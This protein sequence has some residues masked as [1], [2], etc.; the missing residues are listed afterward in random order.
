[1]KNPQEIAKTIKE[2]AKDKKITVG[3]ML[4]DCELG[5]NTL[6]SMQ[7]GGFFP[8]LEAINKIADYLG[9]SVDYLL[10]R[11]ENPNISV[12]QTVNGNNNHSIATGIQTTRSDEIQSD[13][14]AQ[15]MLKQF[16]QLSVVDRSRVILY[17][18]DLNRK[19]I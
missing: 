14:M 18:D 12:V 15:E 19:K 2:L 11:T 10:G 13:E 3:K 6:S 7:A 1:M 5:V 8:R 9:V 17:I 16:N 4:S